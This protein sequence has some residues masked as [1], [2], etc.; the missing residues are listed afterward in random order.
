MCDFSLRH[1]ASRPAKVSEDLTLSM[2]QSTASKAFVG[3]DA[4][5]GEVVCLL[6]GTE[7]EQRTPCEPQ[8][9]FAKL[10][11]K[12]FESKVGVFK[13]INQ[14]KTHTHHDAIEFVGGETVLLQDMLVGSIVR[15]L[16]LPAAPK[17]ADEAKAQE[18]VAIVA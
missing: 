1:L 3:A 14:D 10:F 6:P 4:P 12:T 9:F 13:Q 11:G 2:F 16:Q 18:R 5:V 7:I 17:T 15:V 8:S